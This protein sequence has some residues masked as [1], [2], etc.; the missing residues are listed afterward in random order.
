LAIGL[1]VESGAA[2]SDKAN[3]ECSVLK[4]EF[5][6]NG[7]AASVV[8]HP[9]FEP[10]LVAGGRAEGLAED[11]DERAWGIVLDLESANLLASHF[12]KEGFL[13]LEHIPG[14]GFANF[15]WVRANMVD[16]G[17]KVFGGTVRQIKGFFWSTWGWEKSAKFN[18][19]VGQGS[20]IADVAAFVTVLDIFESTP[21]LQLGEGGKATA[22]GIKGFDGTAGA[23]IKFK[24]FY[25]FAVGF[26]FC[27]E[28]GFGR[29]EGT[30]LDE[31]GKFFS[32]R[33]G[34]NGQSLTL[35]GGESQENKK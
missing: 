18:G 24:S 5:G 12:R 21:R 26:F 35:A 9:E 3:E 33:P 4:F 17:T 22:D 16:H 30:V 20:T 11:F 10:A 15:P 28:D 19:V 6:E 7:N 2:T 23:E 8:G 27:G 29:I 14:D 25:P 13:I 31:V 34:R 32:I 1:E